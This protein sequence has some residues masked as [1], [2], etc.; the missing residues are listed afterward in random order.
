MK[1][2]TKQL[3]GLL[4][5]AS[6]T[7]SACTTHQSQNSGTKDC[8]IPELTGR[9]CVE[10]NHEEIAK[11][12]FGLSGYN[13]VRAQGAVGQREYLSRLI[14]PDGRVVQNFY[15]VGSV[16]I[17]PYGFMLDLYSV[18]CRDESYSVYMDL[19]HQ[20]HVENKPVEGFTIKH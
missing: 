15:R 9:S 10:P 20:G 16:G 17:G 19:Y 2:T 13:P 12:P 4:L 7:L 8:G 3:K 5:V 1:L 11:H 6:C 18:E 14:C